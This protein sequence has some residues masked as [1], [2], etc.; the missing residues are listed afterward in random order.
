MKLLIDINNCNKDQDKSQNL[1]RIQGYLKSIGVDIAIGSIAI[2]KANEVQTRTFWHS[3]GNQFD[4]KEIPRIVSMIQSYTGICGNVMTLHG[5]GVSKRL[6]VY[7]IDGSIIHTSM[8]HKIKGDM[9]TKG[10]FTNIVFIINGEYYRAR[11]S[12][13]RPT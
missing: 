2:V 9:L 3:Q 5:S 6:D 12:R 13:T 1:F 7:G 8:I 11:L 10:S 4:T